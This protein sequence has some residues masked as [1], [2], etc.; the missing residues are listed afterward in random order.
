MYE[1][2]ASGWADRRDPDPL[3]SSHWL[4]EVVITSTQASW[5]QAQKTYCDGLVQDRW[6]SSALA[7]ELCLSCTN[8]SIWSWET[9]YNIS[10]WQTPQTGSRVIALTNCVPQVKVQINIHC[11][12]HRYLARFLIFVTIPSLHVTSW[13]LLKTF[14]KGFQLNDQ[15]LCPQQFP[16]GELQCSQAVDFKYSGPA[17]AMQIQS[18][19][20]QKFSLTS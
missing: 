16:K 18:N 8:P 10:W 12:N 19:F 11:Y 14:P 17:L 9:W 4:Q 2:V 6:N 1:N 20:S 3:A 7:M 13:D 15:E 5:W